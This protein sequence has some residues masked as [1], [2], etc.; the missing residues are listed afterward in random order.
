MSK[1]K[2]SSK[3]ISTMES[4]WQFFDHKGDRNSLLCLF[5][6]KKKANFLLQNTEI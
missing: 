5:C 2:S 4:I 6:L 1:V 3:P